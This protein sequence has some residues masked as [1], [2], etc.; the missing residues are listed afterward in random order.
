MLGRFHVTAPGAYSV[1]ATATLA[2]N[3]VQPQVHLGP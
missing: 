1:A 3:A 2:L